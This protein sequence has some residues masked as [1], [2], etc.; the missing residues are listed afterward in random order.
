MLPRASLKSSRLVRVS[1]VVIVVTMCSQSLSVNVSFADKN[2]TH[3]DNPPANSTSS[4]G[5]EYQ[6][7]VLPILEQYCFGCHA[8]GADEGD[9]SFD[10][11]PSVEAMTTD[12]QTWWSVLKN[13][14]SD[15]MPP[16]GEDQP[17][18]AEKRLL[19]EWITGHVFSSSREPSDPGPGTL[20]RLNRLEYRN[21]IR[22]LMGVEFDT[23][24]EFPPDDS[25]D[26]FDNNADALSISPLLAEK[27]VEAARE[28]V[29][30]AVPKTSR[31]IPIQLIEADAFKTDIDSKSKRLSFDRAAT[32]TA[33]FKVAS[34]AN[35]RVIV[36]IEIDG[37]FDFNSARARVQLLLDGQVLHDRRIRMADRIR[38]TRYR[39]SA[40]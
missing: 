1:L 38:S 13:V 15:V 24:V 36:P 28:I 32:A 3:V 29:D 40:N 6:R 4:V 2:E 35:Y 34:D 5:E 11:F 8:E 37:S 19:F 26:G 21:T 9:F 20:R 10:E 22:D 27:Y 12:T 16:D 25:G 39:S 7:V 18:D 33:K 23:S 17:S 14:R 30:R 31:V